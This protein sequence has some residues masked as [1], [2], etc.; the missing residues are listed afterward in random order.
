M[1]DQSYDFDV[2]VIGAGIAGSVCAYQLANKGHEVLLIERGAEPGSKN[3]SGGVFYCRIMQEIFPDFIES[4]PYERK[5]TRNCVSFLNQDS[6][7]NIDYWDKR[8]VEPVNAV[9]VLRAKFDPWLIEK[10]E[11]SG[12]TVMPGIKVDSLIEENGCYVGVKAG[13]DELRCR[14]VVVA[15]GINSFISK[16]AGLRDKEPTKNLAV[17]VKSVIKLG[18][19]A[20][21][22]RFNLADDEGAAYAIVGDCTKGIAGGGFMYTNKDSVSIGIVTRL[23]DL[24]SKEFSTSDIH[25]YFL[26]HPAIT[27]FLKDGE[28]L[29]YGCHL[30]AEGGREMQHDL[31]HSGMIVLGDAAGFTLNT[32]FTIRGMDLA[33]QSAQAGAEAVHKALEN[34]DY[35]KSSLQYYV[36]CYEQSSLGK[37]MTTYAAAPAFLENE[38]L[39]GEVGKLASD[40]FYGIFNIDL[41]P[42][43]HLLTVARE[44]LKK[45]RFTIPGLIKLGYKA[46]KAM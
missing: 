32:G 8:L 13:E 37:D 33:A 44:A 31:V 16:D 43:K 27:P 18:E 10:C 12:V 28:L 38:V 39:Y 19:Q 26:S 1:E 29:E 22:D 3:L 30:V 25:D 14:V 21:L 11:E 5:I 15:D 9:T 23:D 2:I 20:I 24:A 4:A 17:G 46:T 35:S 40:I 6:F 45:T 7:V 42:R 34:G 36:Q 41:K